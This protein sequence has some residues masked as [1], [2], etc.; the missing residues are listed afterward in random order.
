MTKKY[1]CCVT[2]LTLSNLDE[3][4]PLYGIFFLKSALYITYLKYVEQ[5]IKNLKSS[6]PKLQLNYKK[7]IL[8]SYLKSYNIQYICFLV[9]KMLFKLNKVN[10]TVSTPLIE[11]H[12]HRVIVYHRTCTYS[13]KVGVDTTF[14]M[15]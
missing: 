14:C 3:N 15:T 12:T 2:D 8:S 11:H 4:N 13:L 9:Q 7:K 6:S 5:H 1:D 10:I